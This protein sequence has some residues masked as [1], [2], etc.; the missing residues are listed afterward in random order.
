M[1]LVAEDLGII[2]DEVNALR[3]EYQMPGMKILQFAFG[4]GDDN[5]YL[6]QNIEAN[7]V[8]YT[9]THDNDTSLGW[10]NELGEH[11]RANFHAYLKNHDWQ[12]NSATQAPDNEFS[13]PFSLIKLAMD[14]NA[15][16]AIVPMQDILEMGAESRMNIPGTCQGNWTWRFNWAQLLPEQQ[17]KIMEIYNDQNG[18]AKFTANRY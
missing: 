5:L 7:S 2:T 4:G 11:E 15:E 1:C 3:H 9:G 13:M 17:Q 18:R 10:Y 12:D 14:S 6:P 16:L 8:V